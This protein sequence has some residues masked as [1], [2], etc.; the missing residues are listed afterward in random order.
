MNGAV[1][2]Q[3]AMS[4]ITLLL[5]CGLWLY[6]ARHSEHVERIDRRVS[7]LEER[8]AGMPVVKAQLDALGA[9]M[10]ALSERSAHNYQMTRSIHEYLMENHK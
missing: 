9:Q 3:L 5:V 10:A 7:V 1:D 2:L 4:V 6:V 8:V